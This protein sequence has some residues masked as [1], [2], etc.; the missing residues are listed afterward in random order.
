MLF[1]RIALIAVLV[2]MTATA[3]EAIDEITERSQAVINE[4][5]SHAGDVLESAQKGDRKSIEGDWLTGTPL[6]ESSPKSSSNST[7]QQRAWTEIISETEKAAEGVGQ[8]PPRP[9][10]PENVMYVYISLSMPEETIRALF[11]QALANKELRSVV[12]VLRGWKPPGPNRLVAR[13]NKLFPDAEKLRDLP[14]VQIDPTL[15][16]KQAVDS[17]PTFSTKDES[18]RWGTV[19]GSTSIEDAVKRIESNKYD[20]QV[21]GPTFDIE[22][23]DILALIKERMANVDW[24][25]HVDRVR[26]KVLTKTTTGSKLPVAVVDDSYLVDLTIVNNRDLRGSQGEVFAPAG[27]SVNPFDYMTTHRR[28]VFFDANDPKQLE[29]A[30]QWR[31]KHAYTTMI[32]TVPMSSEHLRK[33]VIG[34]LKQPVHEINRLIIKRFNLTAVPAIAYQEGRM[35]RVDVVAPGDSLRAQ[36]KGEGQ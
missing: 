2:C 26:E 34:M 22:E 10:V 14:N 32:T 27:V 17:V 7:A 36:T 9:P 11:L 29:Q 8:G 15:F 21:I 16:S 23:P 25:S 24:N 19:V 6:T 28:F 18:G 30:V 3:D 12:F 5:D 4:A 33:E 13:L 20:G 31:E 35:L 1:S